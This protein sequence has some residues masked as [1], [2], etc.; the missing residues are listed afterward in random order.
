[1][2]LRLSRSDAPLMRFC[3]ALLLWDAASSLWPRAAVSAGQHAHAAF[4]S[5]DAASREDSK[6]GFAGP[7][8]STDDI[9]GKE[10]T[11]GHRRSDYG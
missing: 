10:W 1:M 4:G 5:N 2:R 7:A 6:L 9:Y 3:P 11:A 8:L